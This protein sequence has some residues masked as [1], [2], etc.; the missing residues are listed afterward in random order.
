M[1]ISEFR[2]L[3]GTNQQGVIDIIRTRGAGKASKCK[4]TTDKSS[5]LASQLS[6]AP[7][8]EFLGF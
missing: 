2:E 7:A 5:Q 6:R 3:I 4:Q 1:V 8:I